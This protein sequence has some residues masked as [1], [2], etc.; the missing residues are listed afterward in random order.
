MHDIKESKF[1]KSELFRH[2]SLLNNENKDN[3]TAYFLIE[4]SGS[5]KQST[6]VLRCRWTA[7]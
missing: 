5:F 6:I 7:L 2:I 1:S 4:T 3:E